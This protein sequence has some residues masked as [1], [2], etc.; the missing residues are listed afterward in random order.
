MSSHPLVLK[1]ASVSR[2]SGEWSIDDYD[3]VCEGLVGRIMKA[4]AAPEASPWFWSLTYG[5][6]YDRTPTHGYAAPR[7]AATAPASLLRSPLTSA[8]GCSRKR[9]SGWRMAARAMGR[10]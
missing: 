6:H 5:Y 8:G 2:S 4:A 10:A 3:V 9:P 1:R 7:E